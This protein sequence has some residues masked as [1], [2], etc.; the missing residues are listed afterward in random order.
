ML[1]NL[2]VD[3]NLTTYLDTVDFV[4]FRSCCHTLYDDS[5]AWRL[6]AEPLPH[7]VPTLTDKQNIGL[8]YLL[9]WARRIC[10]PMGSLSWYQHVVEWIRYKITIRIVFNF[11]Q[12]Q[13]RE[14][15]MYAIDTA[16]LTS[17]QQCLWHYYTHR[18]RRLFK[19]K[20]RHTDAVGQ[21]YRRLSC[22][23]NLQPCVA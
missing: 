14:Y 8:D 1:T 4:S 9:Q 2:V 21:K 16:P 11:L 18:S 13:N 23:R 5:E 6:R 3:R 22:P 15:L 10:Q 12:S 20:R 17:S 7:R 19:R